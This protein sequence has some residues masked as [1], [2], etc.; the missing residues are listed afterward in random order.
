MD[1]LDGLGETPLSP[2]FRSSLFDY[3]LKIYPDVKEVQLIPTA[4][5]DDATI[6]I[7]VDGAMNG[8]VAS[9]NAS[10]RIPLRQSDNTHITIDVETQRGESFQYR[11]CPSVITNISAVADDIDADN[12][13]LI[14]LYFLEDVNAIRHNRNGTDY[15]LT[16]DSDPTQAGC[17]YRGCKGY[18]LVRSLDFNDDADYRDASANKAKWTTE[19]GWS[20]ITI[21]GAFNGNG[22]TISNLKINRPTSNAVGYSA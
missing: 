4:Y 14:E 6:R 16:S 3:N 10:G 19:S 20:P 8:T 2:A 11:N 13:G 9:G 12:D 21:S 15:R 18:E 1:D 17:P 5:D 22:H 7:V